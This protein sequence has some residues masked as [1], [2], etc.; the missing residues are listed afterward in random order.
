M[1]I[2]VTGASG[3][4][5]SALVSCLEGEGHSV[6]RLVRRESR[7]PDE[8]RW[9]PGEGL[10]DASP[11][12]ECEAV[13][14]L[15]GENIAG[16]RWNE[17]RK[18]RILESRS[19]GTLL[20]ARTLASLRQP[21]EV[22]VS[23]S[24]MGYYG[25]RGDEILSE[26]SGPGV[27]FLPDVCVAWEAATAPAS[28][29]GIRTVITRIGIVL[30]ADGGALSRMLTPFRLGLGGPIGS[31]DQFWSWIALDDVVG[32]I[33]F[34]IRSSSVRGPV[35]AVAPRA[36]TSREF[37]RVLAGVLGRPGAFP[38]PAFV[39]RLAMGEMADELLLASARVEPRRIVA[40]GYEFRYP[41]LDAAIR[42]VLDK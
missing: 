14:H 31:G 16:G 30:T 5:G 15:A 1:R 29:G 32:I 19:Q 20:L 33:S 18:R 28:A 17:D 12:E 2:A 25:S 9:N 26:D 21:P 35:N 10:I 23:A 6:V 4:I 13:V 27:G 3:L 38:L 40:A 24:A 7:G 8:I 37:A 22:L 36:A 34:A 11:L 39:T 41:A 42:H